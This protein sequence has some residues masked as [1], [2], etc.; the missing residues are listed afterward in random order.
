MGTPGC[1]WGAG[2]GTAAGCARWEPSAAPCAGL[3]TVRSSVG[4]TPGRGRKKPTK[5]VNLHDSYDSGGRGNAP[6]RSEVPLEVP[7]RL[8]PTQLRRP[9]ARRPGPRNVSR[10]PQGQGRSSG[11]PPAHYNGG[12]M[13]PLPHRPIPRRSRLTTALAIS[14]GL[15]L[16]LLPWIAKDA[17]FH[18][19]A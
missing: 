11:R 14:L 1:S 5:Y 15:H 7:A 4:T 9:A 17:V 10:R 3:D 2:G 6:L 12:S 16:L 8:L 18:I 19:P 13:S